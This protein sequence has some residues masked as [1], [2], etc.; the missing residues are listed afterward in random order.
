MRKQFDRKKKLS[1]VQKRALTKMIEH[2]GWECAYSLGFNMNTLDALVAHKYA[3]LRGYDKT[4]AF[5]MPR[6]T[7]EYKAIR[8][9][10][11]DLL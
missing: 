9:H 1:D 10:E 2:G 5:S 6:T 7:V 11:G 4:G 3:K 8:N